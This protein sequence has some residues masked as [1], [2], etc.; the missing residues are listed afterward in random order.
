MR[1][2]INND[3][4]TLFF[5]LALGGVFIYASIYK[6]MD[7]SSFALSIWYY[8]MVPG[9][10]INMMALIL[11]WLEL[12]CGLAL[13]AGI[14][15][16]G[17]IFWTTIMLVIFLAALTS[18]ISRGLSIDCGCFKQG[19]EGTSAAW[20]SLLLDVGLFIGVVQLWLSRSTRWMLGRG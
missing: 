20:R 11:P 8:H 9:N 6:I 13:I 12:L 14:L 3:W 1:K 17:A 4:L 15:Y 10:M 18:A 19:G 5:R 7:P 2:L 16:R